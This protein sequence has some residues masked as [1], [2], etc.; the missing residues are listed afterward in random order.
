MIQ[1]LANRAFTNSWFNTT[2]DLNLTK[3]DLVDLLSVATKGQLFQFNGALYEQTDGVAMES[4]L[5]PLL[6]YVFMSHIEEILEQEGKL[7]S[8]YRR[9][10][11]D[12]FTIMPNIE[13]ASIGNFLDTLNKAH[14]SVKFR[15]ETE[16]NVMLPF[17]GIQLLN[18]SPQI[19]TKE[20]VKPTNSGLLLHYQ[21]HVDNRY[22]KGLLR[23]ML[24]R[25][26]RLSSS[27]THFSDECDHL[28]TVLSRLKYPV[29]LINSTI[30]SFVDSKVCDQQ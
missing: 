30:K 9:Y 11:D 24:D 29:H 23:T 7:P 19:E 25:A 18:R 3:S 22:K 6:A 17:L 14:S 20:Y 27:W 15:M 8:F 4:P 12:T 21:S 26:H 2:Y 28:K 5:G 13:T 10:V 1:L 16:C